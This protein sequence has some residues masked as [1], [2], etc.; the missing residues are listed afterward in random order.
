AFEPRRLNI[1]TSEDFENVN[2]HYYVDELNSYADEHVMLLGGVD[3]AVDW[4]L[5]LEPIADKVMLVHRRNQFR[6]HR[7]SIERIK[8]SSVNIIKTLIATA[9]EGNEKRNR[10]ILQLI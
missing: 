5:M 4:A 7:N 3:S 6:A 1:N 8:A 9:I 10:I 2:L